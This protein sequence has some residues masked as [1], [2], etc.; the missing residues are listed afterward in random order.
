[1]K[2]KVRYFKNDN[3]FNSIV[4][5]RNES[6]ELDQVD[7]ISIFEDIP[8]LDKLQFS[9]KDLHRIKE[10][11]LFLEVDNTIVG[12][13]AFSWWEEADGT[14]VY[15]HNEYILPTY[16]TSEVENKFLEKI[17]E[18]I[19]DL[20]KDQGTLNKAVFGTN[21]SENESWKSAFLISN[22]YKLV[23]TMVE[24]EF[25]DF[26]R[27]HV[28]SLPEG[29]IIKSP[30]EINY[31]D[32]WRLNK[33]V[34]NG[35]W[36]SMP[37][38]VDDFN[39]FVEDNVS[40]I[41]LCDIAWE[42]RKIIGFVLSKVSNGVGV[43]GQVT[44]AKEYQRRGIGAALLTNNLL[45]LPNRGIYK[46]RLYTDA[47]NKMGGKGLYEKIG[48]YPLKFYFRYRKPIWIETFIKP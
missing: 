1:M 10:K 31:L 35:T 36:G 8:T 20:S 41:E 33:D 45:K 4:K 16:R 37:S 27:I 43:M 28:S 7:P 38:T 17:H 12:Y 9:F 14:I 6:K 18:H 47:E 19:F 26:N 42:D 25:T 2:V 21:I 3:D 30:S 46:A 32:M 39:E 48:F 44:I 23:W 5:I 13:A 24:M 40:D 22:G 29:V 34:Y 15:L 11:L